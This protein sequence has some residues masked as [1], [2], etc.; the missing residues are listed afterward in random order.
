[1][2]FSLQGFLEKHLHDRFI[3]LGVEMNDR[4]MVRLESIQVKER[5]HFFQ[6]TVVKPAFHEGKIGQ[7]DAT[8]ILKNRLVD[9]EA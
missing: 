7:R 8:N 9:I 4:V 2:V 3:L 1:M 5:G 6:H